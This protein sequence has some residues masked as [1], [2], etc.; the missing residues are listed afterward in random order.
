MKRSHESYWDVN[1]GPDFMRNVAQ[2][3]NPIRETMAEQAKEAGPRVLDIACSSAMSYPYF[4][5][6][7]VEYVGVDFTEKFLVH[8]RELYPG[9]EV[10][11]RSALD[12]GF[13]DGSFPTV[14]T[15]DL[16]EHVAPEDVPI[17]IR[18]MWDIAS[19]KMMIAFFLTPIPE[20]AVIRFVDGKY[21]NNRY[22]EREII[23]LIEGLEGFKEFR[24]LNIENRAV[25]GYTHSPLYIAE[26][27]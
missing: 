4:A 17:I 23:G 1:V 6:E 2:L 16:L 13:P 26:K 3:S 7:G 11:N 27:K 9:I 22:D 12:P 25:R 8:A 5:V 21:Y 19:R 18:K 24:I 15:K 10:Y 20:P 14:C